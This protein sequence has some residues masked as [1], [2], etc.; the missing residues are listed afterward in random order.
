[1]TPRTFATEQAEFNRRHAVEAAGLI[2][3][4]SYRAQS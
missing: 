3:T 4:R 1:M 2:Q